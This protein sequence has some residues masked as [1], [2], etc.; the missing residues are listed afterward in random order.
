MTG[1]GYVRKFVRF[2]RGL[3]YSKV[4][5]S[6]LFNALRTGF[7]HLSYVLLVQIAVQTCTIEILRSRNGRE[8]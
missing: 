4:R 2:E 6:V 1:R 5:V 3:S 8:L 7:L